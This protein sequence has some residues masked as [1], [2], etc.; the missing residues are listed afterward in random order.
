MPFK[1]P[2][3]LLQEQLVQVTV[4]GPPGGFCVTNLKVDGYRGAVSLSEGSGIE[5]K[6]GSKT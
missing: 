2:A 1:T 5:V 4:A 6:L 3:A